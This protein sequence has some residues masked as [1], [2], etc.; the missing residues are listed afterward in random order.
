MRVTDQDSQIALP[1]GV[2]QRDIAD[3]IGI[4]ISTV[5]R[6]LSGSER[7]SRRTLDDV[8]RAIETLRH[9]QRGDTTR[10]GRGLIG[11][12]TSHLSDEARASQLD[13]IASQVLGGAEL[14]AHQLGHRIYTARDSKLLLD[15]SNAD[16]L[17]SMSGLLLTGGMVNQKVL[18]FALQSGLPVCIVGG[19]VP[20]RGVPSVAADSQHGMYLATRHLIELGH[21]RIA[22]VN[23]PQATY[24]SHE[25]LAGYLSALTEANL[26]A[27]LDLVAWF[28]WFSAF[29]SASG[30][31]TMNHLLT[32][33]EP[34]TGII[35]ATD[36]LAMGAI[37]LLERR[38]ISVPEQVSITGFHDDPFATAVTPQLTTIRVDRTMWG[39]RAVKRVIAAERG[40]AMQADRLLL[41]VELV[42]RD[43]TGPAPATRKGKHS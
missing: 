32:L 22:L 38:G 6:A 1:D 20:E 4:S 28:H 33:G 10:S 29:D 16:L 40:E 2:S 13:L 19:H 26:P 14:A 41:P 43:S 3:E 21:T 8:Q 5:S 31:E 37:S 27:S 25:K 36:E 11:L 23:G 30:L 34:P 24:T 42:V 15:P 12:T 39:D 7:V 35:F 17:E 18:D 9:R